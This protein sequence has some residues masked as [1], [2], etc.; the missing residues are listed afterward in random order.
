MFILRLIR[1]PNIIIILLTQA[2]LYYGLIL[3][4]FTKHS[5]T[6]EMGTVGFI[7]MF[8]ITAI[9]TISG[10]IINDIMDVK[11]D[12]FNKKDRLILTNQITLK[13]AKILYAALLVFGFGLSLHYAVKHDV[14]RLLFI[15]PLA[16]ALLALYSSHLKGL[17]FTGNIVV[18]LFSGGVAAILFL[19]EKKAFLQLKTDQFDT[20]NTVSQIM[21]AFIIFAFI[22]SLYREIIKDMEDF[23][24]DRANDSRTG[25]V[26]L[27]LKKTKIVTLFVGIC[28]IASVITWLLMPINNGL[29]LFIS[30]GII[31][32]VIGLL[33]LI[34]LIKSEKKQDFHTLSQIIKIIMLLGLIYLTLYIF[35]FPNLHV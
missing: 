18:S 16:C 9:V 6:S 7:N 26:L 13:S 30:G 11:I 34:L 35:S 31:I 20:Y 2:L 17:G 27:G 19:F 15:Y 8:V 32:A 14:I 5:I 12:T 10:Y 3:P 21:W 22:S 23:E 33:T 4:A 29:I 28:F 24:G 1:L 25:A